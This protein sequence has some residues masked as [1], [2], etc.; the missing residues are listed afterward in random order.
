MADPRSAAKRGQ[1][2]PYDVNG[3]PT[4]AA[5]A[6][7][8]VSFSPTGNVAATNVQ[9]AI[10]E[11]DAEK[12]PL[13]ATLTNFAGLAWTGGVEV[14]VLTA[15][16]AFSLRAVGAAAGANILDR[17]A[18]D[19]RYSLLAHTH[20]ASGITDFA[21]AVDDRVSALLVGG[22]NIGLTYDDTANSMTIA[23]TGL[24][25]IA[26]SGSATELTTGTVPSARMPALTGDV[27]TVAGAVATTIAN[28]AVT[29]AKM[30][31][32]SAT[33][34]LLGRFSA[35]A[36]DVEEISC[37]AF[38]RS[39]IDDSDAAAGR[40]TLG[41][42]AAALKNIGTSGDAVPV[43]NGAATTWAAGATFGGAV[44]ITGTLAATGRADIANTVRATGQSSPVSGS[45]VEMFYSGGGY[46]AA[47]D[48]TG[49][50]YLVLNLHGSTVNLGPG[51]GAVSITS[52][53]FTCPSSTTASAA[54]VYQ[55]SSGSALLRSTSSLRYKT[56]IEDVQQTYADAALSLRPVWYR[57][58]ADGDP[59]TFSYWGY[60]AEEVAA[61]D[62]RLVHWAYLETDYTTVDGERVPKAGA[63]KVPEGAQYER[64]AVLQIAALKRRVEELESRLLAAG[65]F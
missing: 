19:G 52:S 4:G 32:L 39:L 22:S 23:V 34:R 27:T 41:L 64:I 56:Q 16:D 3:A 7:S 13:D 33:D 15:A 50:A 12:Q 43:L 48:R 44:S 65:I 47:Y 54:N 8:D 35:G 5:G 38:G 40:A 58:L 55:A 20:A 10:A 51:S 25:A 29:Y 6:A 18:G 61:I 11:V 60:I 26:T 57:S 14:P 53:A 63:V 17:A 42:G 49:A 2:V 36:G 1:V 21:E 24:A 62:P 28:D 30:Q 31:N 59:H 46:V 9:A 45:G 37:T